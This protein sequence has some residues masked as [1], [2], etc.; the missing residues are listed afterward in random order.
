MTVKEFAL[1]Q[2]HWIVRKDPWVREIFLAAGVT[3]DEMAER[4]LAIWNGDDFA[5][6]TEAQAAYYE[7][8]LGLETDPEI[9][10]A[11]RRA[12]IQAAWNRGQTPSLLSIQGVCDAWE[13]G[14]ILVS[15]AD[16]VLTLTFQ[17]NVGVPSNL[18]ALKAA[19]E[20]TAPAHLVV[21]YDFRFLLIREVH[22]VMTLAELDAE[23]LNHFAS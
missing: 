8:L 6:L 15:Y 14:G 16:G 11:D 2:L 23:P 3:L 9:P 1:N 22:G 10:L 17:G 7:G 20:A 21:V 12:A 19:I 18:D 13:E 5:R 4:I